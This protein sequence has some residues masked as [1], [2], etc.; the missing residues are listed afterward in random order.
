MVAEGLPNRVRGKPQ[1]SLRGEMLRRGG[2][3][4]D[5]GRRTGRYP[6]LNCCC[7]IGCFPVTKEKQEGKELVGSEQ[8]KR[9]CIHVALAQSGMVG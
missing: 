5:R 4:P 2:H 8:D 6:Q 1:A 7:L 3:H 9:S